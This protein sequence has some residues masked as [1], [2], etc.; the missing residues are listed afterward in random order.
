[1]AVVQA[2]SR[3]SDL[4]PSLGISIC[5]RCGPK[6]KKKSYCKNHIISSHILGETLISI[7]HFTTEENEERSERSSAF[8]KVIQPGN[9][10][11]QSIAQVFW[12]MAQYTF[13]LFLSFFSEAKRKHQAVVGSFLLGKESIQIH[14]V[15]SYILNAFLIMLRLISL[16]RIPSAY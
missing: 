16:Y 2:S 9:R 12:V 4:T 5:Y 10:K 6:K 1:M 7:A 3:S 11:G 14:L 8:S 15:L 13:L